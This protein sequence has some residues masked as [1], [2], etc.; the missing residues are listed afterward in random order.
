MDAKASGGATLQQPYLRVV[1]MTEESE[2]H[3]ADSFT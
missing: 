3:K 1:G 2:G